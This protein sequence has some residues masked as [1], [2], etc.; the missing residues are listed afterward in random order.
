MISQTPDQH[1]IIDAAFKRFT[2]FGPENTTMAQ[3]AKDLG[4]SR[5]FLYYYFPDKESIYKGALIRRTDKY[6]DAVEKEVKKP[7][8]GYKRLENVLKVKVGCT[9]DFQSLGVYTNLTLF[10]MLNTDPELAYIFANELKIFTRLI[11][12]GI[13]DGSVEKCNANKTAQ[14][15]LDGLLGYSAI[16]LRRLGIDVKLTQSQ[17]DELRKKQSEF[18]LF[19][20]QAIQK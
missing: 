6:F 12:E 15:L 5:T 17:L 11:Q 20:L 14:W 18:G 10:K 2:K 1:K 3:I 13:K 16:R 9:K 7:L 4:Y 19:L 8:S